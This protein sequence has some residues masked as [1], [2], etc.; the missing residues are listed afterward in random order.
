MT[1]VLAQTGMITGGWEYV[2]AAYVLTW[3]FLGGY[4]A[5]LWVRT[6]EER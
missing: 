4:A 1:V 5:S 6:R 3:L 2:V